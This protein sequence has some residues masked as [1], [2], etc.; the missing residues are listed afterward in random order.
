MGSVAVNNFEDGLL[1]E[2]YK[3]FVTQLFSRSAPSRGRQ[4]W[5]GLPQSV[6]KRMDMPL[7]GPKRFLHQEQHRVGEGKVTLA[8]ESFLVDAVLVT[9]GLIQEQAAALGEGFLAP[10]QGLR[11]LLLKLWSLKPWLLPTAMALLA[12]LLFQFQERVAVD[13]H[14]ASNRRWRNCR[15]SG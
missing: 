15:F 2:R 14:A 9:K 3:S 5:T 4:S 13:T 10:T 6:E 7:N 12:R 8:C 1:I 11:V